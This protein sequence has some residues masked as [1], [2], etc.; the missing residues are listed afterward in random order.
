MAIS[1]SS[2]QQ[3]DTPNSI[4]HLVYTAASLEQG[5]DAIEDLL[6]VRPVLGGSHPQFGTRNALLSL[7]PNT[8]LEIIAPDPELPIPSGGLLFKD[9]FQ[10]A[11]QL[12]RWVVRDSELEQTTQQEKLKGYELGKV[13]EGS[14]KTPDGQILSWKLTD[15]TVIPLEGAVP[16]LIDWGLTPHPASSAPGGV[17]LVDFYVEH[18]QPEVVNKWY[19]AIGIEVNIKKAKKIRLVAVIET[20]KGTVELY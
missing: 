5:M 4:D 19:Q 13:S 17:K 18:P 10:S 14:R 20:D 12:A 2:R 15:P 16:F 3:Q 7:G 8:Y 1:S 11:P 9:Y 6:G